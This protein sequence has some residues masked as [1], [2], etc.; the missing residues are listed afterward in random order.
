MTAG[1]LS[2]PSEAKRRNCGGR[3]VS[4]STLGMVSYWGL[5]REHVRAIGA[6]RAWL[7]DHSIVL[8]L[9]TRGFR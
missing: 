6:D 8:R 3:P 7:S 9:Q 5:A 1:A 2:T 4:Y